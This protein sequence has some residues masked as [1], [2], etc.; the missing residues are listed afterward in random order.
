MAGGNQV[1]RAGQPQRPGPDHAWVCAPPPVGVNCPHRL[2][3]HVLDANHRCVQ[4]RAVCQGHVTSVQVG[5]GRHALFWVDKWLDGA[6]VTQLVPALFA[7][8]NKRRQ[9][10]R[11]VREAV[12]GG[13]WIGDITGSLS[14]QALV[15]YVR[16]W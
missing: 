9:S 1:D 13:L 11:L 16:L 10:T 12:D 4:V 14:T 15:E 6:S 3:T 2:R 8:V 5:D 7:V